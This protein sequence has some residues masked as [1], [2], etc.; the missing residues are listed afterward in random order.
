[1][2]DVTQLTQEQQWGLAF[3]VQTANAAIETANEPKA[4]EDKQPLFTSASYAGVVMRSACDSYYQQLITFKKTNALAMFDAL[5]SEEQAAIISQLGIP[6]V[7][8]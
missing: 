3:A 1:M 2:I 8:Q 4:E 6:D 7:L 5:S